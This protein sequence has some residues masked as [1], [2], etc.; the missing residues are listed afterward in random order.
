MVLTQCNNTWF[1]VDW[2][3]SAKEKDKVSSWRVYLIAS[4]WAELQVLHTK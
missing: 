4:E 2:E 1:F 3:K